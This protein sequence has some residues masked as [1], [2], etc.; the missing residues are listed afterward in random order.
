MSGEHLGRS[1]PRLSLW[2]MSIAFGLTLTMSGCRNHRPGEEARSGVSF[3]RAVIKVKDKAIIV[4]VANT[5]DRIARGLMY[6]DSLPRDEG[7]L[8]VY[9]VE[10]ILSFWMRNTRIPLDVAFI[11]DDGTIAQIA[12][13]EPSSRRSYVSEERARF[14]LEMN[15]GWFEANGVTVGDRARISGYAGEATR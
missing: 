6:R 7:M 5:P 3:D 14:A 4:E 15:S 10:Q 13:M 8:F 1:G 11:Q 12:R 9:P 2:Q